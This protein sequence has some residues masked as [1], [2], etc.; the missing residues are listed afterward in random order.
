MVGRFTLDSATEFLFGKSVRSL[1]A[2]LVY[3]KN[4]V[5]VQN[6]EYTIHPSDVF[7][8]A[9]SEAQAQVSFRSRF[10]SFWRLTEF[11]GDRVRKQVEVCHRF[12]DPILKDALE[13]KGKQTT[14]QVR[15]EEKE[16]LADT[17]LGHLV[18]CTEDLT[19]IRDEIVNILIAARD[20]VSCWVILVSLFQCKPQQTT[21]TL[22]FL[23]YMLSQHQKFWS[24][25]VRK[26]LEGW[27]FQKTD[28][29][30]RSKHEVYASCHQ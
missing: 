23:V 2:G 14:A 3:P 16:A 20:T 28:V 5:P 18:N 15:T 11:W 24:D 21:A 29:R 8:H 6:K 22:T 17:L 12:I 19:V 30:R 10:G 4:C 1:S 25:C 26:F 7:A 27:K 9:F 13:V